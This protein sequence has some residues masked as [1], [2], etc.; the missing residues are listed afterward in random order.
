MEIL[1][2]K[3]IEFENNF[4]E[5]HSKVEE[6]PYG[7]IFYNEENP[8]SHDSNHAIIKEDADYEVAINE[9]VNFYNS[10]NI[11]PRV[12]TL[13]A[14]TNKSNLGEYLEGKGFNTV[15]EEIRYFI[16]KTSKIINIA[17]TLKIVRLK[18]IDKSVEELLYSD[19]NEGEWSYKTLIKSIDKEKFYLFAG[20]EG[21]ELV[22]IASLHT[23]DDI[24]RI[25]NVFTRKNK[26][27][28]GYCTQLIDFI[29]KYNDEF[30]KTIIYLYASNPYA[31]KV[32]KKSGF[33]EMAN[34]IS[35]YYW[36]D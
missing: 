22:C 20:Y 26:R 17:K 9:V 35:G 31:I 19:E 2:D 34:F 25:D 36:L 6:K 15:K 16:Q 21:E 18:I 30:L 1:R 24:S 23:Q 10:R 33:E 11:T 7:K 12:Y 27:R 28:Y 3:I 29:T 14:N 13:T 5:V 4:A 32:Y 8:L